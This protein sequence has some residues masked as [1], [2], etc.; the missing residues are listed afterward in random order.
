MS[1]LADCRLHLFCNLYR[2][3]NGRGWDEGG[4]SEGGGQGPSRF[5]VGMFG[6]GF[7]LG[8]AELMAGGADILGQLGELAPAEQYDHRHYEDDKAVRPE[9]ICSHFGISLSN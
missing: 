2:D 8:F 1:H 6:L 5:G 3:R 4:G 7:A 9:D